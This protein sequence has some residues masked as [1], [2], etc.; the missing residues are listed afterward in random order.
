MAEAR[1]A[2]TVLLLRDGR[3]GLE[4]AMMRRS[5]KT[6]FLPN[7]LVFPGGAVDETDADGPWPNLENSA[8]RA[9]F[10]MAVGMAGIRETFEEVGLLLARGPDGSPSDSV[11]QE[12]DAYREL[13]PPMAAFLR[14]RGLEPAIADLVIMARWITPEAESKRY[15]TWFFAA[16]APE[17]QDL[18]PHLDEASEAAW[19]RPCDVI[20]EAMAQR[21]FLAPPTLYVLEQVS[22]CSAAEEALRLIRA[23]PA[24][25]CR[26]VM[27]FKGEGIQ[28]YLPGDPEHP[29]PTPAYPGKPT[30]VVYSGSRWW[31]E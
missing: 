14:D 27:E 1:P 13:S 8:S 5:R 6:G 28:I 26:P 12:R 16:R 11:L 22:A 30:R 20:A 7:V 23:S 21:Q 24:P 4:V 17:G 15:D 25:V 29:D 19:L 10:P 2:A 18:R 3:N 31:R 9:D